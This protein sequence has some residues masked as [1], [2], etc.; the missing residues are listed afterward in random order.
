MNNKIITRFAPSPTGAL[1]IGAA[2]TALFNFLFSKQQGGDML[3]RI[4]DTDKER[5][6][7][8][9]EEE[10]I[11][12]LRWLS[13]SYSA[14]HKQSDRVHL[15]ARY[16]A[17]LIDDNYA[18]PAE[19]GVI[20]FKNPNKIISF[21][22]RIR[23][24]ITTDTTDLGDFVIARNDKDPLYHLAV[25]I[26]DYEMGITHVIRG[27]EHISNTP[28][29]ILI[30]EAIGATRPEYAHIPLI[31]SPD[32]SKLSKRH[33]AMP[34]LDYKKE[35]YVPEAIV[36]F[37]ALLGWSP[38][39]NN[40]SE[41]EIFTLEELASVFSLE[42]VQ[43]SGAIFDIIKLK[44]INREH[45]KQL[46][47]ERLEQE[48]RPFLPL[49]SKNM[50]ESAYGAFVGML[51]EKIDTFNDIRRLYESG[52]LSYLWETP[53]YEKGGLLWKNDNDFSVV[54]KHIDE[55]I[56]LLSDVDEKQFTAAYI[57]EK[58]WPYATEGGRGSVLWPFRYALSGKEKSAD[59]FSIAHI[60]GKKETKLI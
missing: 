7:K 25:V 41:K 42:G 10:I 4:E 53:E 59:P 34:V 16:I 56:K 27:E 11:E 40:A 5:S 39:H 55:I 35:G 24:D 51:V 18:Y 36:N 58:I 49:E 44:W 29:Q 22:D 2:R 19:D 31:L 17:R 21:H 6:K 28:R 52:E 43:K 57:K 15:Y 32:R 1:H 33:G 20:R 14:L 37:M 47:G 30:Q 60:V 9:Y 38:Q 13:I 48:I 3:L 26:D 45:I 46:P 8:I 54:R 50:S 23:G 12:S